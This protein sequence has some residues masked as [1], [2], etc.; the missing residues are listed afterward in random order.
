MVLILA[1]AILLRLLGCV[2]SFSV[3]FLIFKSLILTRTQVMR[4]L[5]VVIM[6]GVL[7]ALSDQN[8][9]LTLPLYMWSMLVTAEV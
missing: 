5:L 4:Y 1:A 2:E 7:E 9:N 8:D 3:C 6:S